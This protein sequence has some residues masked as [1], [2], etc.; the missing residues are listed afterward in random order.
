MSKTLIFTGGGSG[1]HVM[2]ALTIIKKININNQYDVHYIGGI[3]SIEREL[4]TD[5]ELTYHPIHTGKLRRYLSIENFKD[6][7]NVFIGLI[8]AF[9]VLW[10]F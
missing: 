4:V 3:K 8:D 10:K 5:Y 7:L 2:P 1:G 6:T 9:K